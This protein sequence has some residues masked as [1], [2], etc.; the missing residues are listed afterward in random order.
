M[1]GT[2]G[3]IAGGAAA[4]A[5]A[6]GSVCGFVLGRRGRRGGGRDAGQHAALSSVGAATVTLT[7]R[8]DRLVFD[9]LSASI[10]TVTGYSSEVLGKG[11]AFLRMLSE[12]DADALER[13]AV[14]AIREERA[15]I[16]D[17]SY[18]DSGGR[19]RWMQLRAEPDGSESGRIGRL[20]GV[21]R[22]VTESKHLAGECAATWARFHAL[23]DAT[24]AMLWVLDASGAATAV[25][26]A[27]ERFCA[28]SEAALLGDGWLLAVADGH[29][30]GL[31]QFV[32]RV[33]EEGTSLTREVAMND[34]DGRER[35]ISMTA[36]AARDTDGTVASIVLTGRDIT[37][38]SEHERQRE[39]MTRLIMSLDNPAMIVAPDFRVAMLNPSA[40]SR[41]GLGEGESADS[42]ALW[43]VV[44]QDTVD[45]IRAE[46]VRCCEGGGV[47][48]MQGR[49]RDGEQA[50]V[51]SELLIVGLGEGWLGV[52]AREIELELEREAEA[53]LDRRR[54]EVMLGALERLSGGSRGTGRAAG[55]VVEALAGAY[56]DLRAA[57]SSS[58]D[59][60]VLRCVA[61][62]EPA[63]MGSAEGR[64][65]RLDPDGSLMR[66]LHQDEAVQVG[67][68]WTESQLAGG[69]LAFEETSARRVAM[70]RVATG[71]PGLS[72]LTIERA[73]P[74]RWSRDEIQSLELAARLLG[75]ALGAERD[76]R[77]RLA[78]EGRAAE[79]MRRWHEERERSEELSRLASDRVAENDRL[80]NR[81][82]KADVSWSA[83]LAE[84]GTK[85][86]A[87]AGLSAEAREAGLDSLADRLAR[88][89]YTAERGEVAGR[90]G[91]GSLKSNPTPFGP[92]DLLKSVGQRLVGDAKARGVSLRISQANRLPDRIIGD[93]RLLR[94]ACTEL[95]W[96][97]IERCS[98]KE[99]RAVARLV[100][101]AGSQCLELS[102]T[103]G[104]VSA[105]TG[106]GEGAPSGLAL[107]RSLAPA[108]GGVFETVTEGAETTL[109]LRIPASEATLATGDANDDEPL[110]EAA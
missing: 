99:L 16:A 49:V 100:E 102:I 56:P 5:L 57:F 63:W 51:A 106:T 86:S 36:T 84:L 103:G 59:Q 64:G 41:A 1:L 105:P 12:A 53:Q 35:L 21:L 13:R 25:N 24:P 55:R 34:P 101:H 90:L 79:Q 78:A 19:T 54:L 107:L 83:A 48:R 75:L 89:A 33:G 62:D 81:L 27:T 9:D 98:T 8:G 69:V 87:A 39:R 30:E 28:V 93:E 96:Y 38:R 91:T 77:G 29:Q 76:R 66:S 74:G 80:L 85:T 2:G 92:R 52:T 32:R 6:A 37:D 61:S 73:T 20:R 110:A 71:E 70:L 43:H 23:A 97:A 104:A 88:L 68:V 67:D 46:A 40:R 18:E 3:L 50:S 22:E 10:E 44:T 45:E 42:L 11:D 72:V 26:R 15:M 65:F 94:V 47:Y 58:D 95:L 17:F 60:G 82:Q 31:V 109:T 108:L 7:L 14:A 4:V